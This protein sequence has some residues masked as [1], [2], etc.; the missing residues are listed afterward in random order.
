M[1]QLMP[2][3]MLL[4]L[5]AATALLLCPL[6][7]AAAAG[8]SPKHRV[9]L[10]VTFRA[11]CPACQWF[12]GD[13]LLELIRN[14]DFR[15]IVDLKLLPA[16]G[17]TE[18]NGA[19]DCEGGEEECDGHRWEACVIDKDRDD[20]VKYLGGIACIE[21][22]ESG[23][24]GEWTTK[25]DNCFTPE[26]RAVLKDCYEKKSMA[27][28]TNMI[29]NERVSEVGWMPYTVV[30]ERVLGS[31]SRG[32]GLDELQ[33]SV[34][35]EYKGPKSFYPEA[36]VKLHGEQQE[37]APE[38]ADADAAA[39]AAPTQVPAA[40]TPAA[41]PARDE[42]ANNEPAPA[43]PAP[44]A[45]VVDTRAKGDD[46]PANKVRVEVY[47]RAFCPGCMYFI[48]KPLLMLLRDEQFR[49]IVD[50]RP[51]P[52]AGTFLDAKGNFMCNKGMLECVGHKWLSCVI[53]QFPDLGEQ[54]EHL[55]CMEN[56]DNKGSSWDSI[57]AK[58]FKT[59]DTRRALKQCF[60]TRSSALLKRHIAQREKVDVHWM[61][62][63]LVNGAPVGDARHGIGFK[64][65]Q[66]EV[67]KAY[68]G[69]AEMRPVACLPKRLRNE[70][71]EEDEPPKQGDQAVRPCPQKKEGGGGAKY[72]DAPGAGLRRPRDAD[73][74]AAAAADARPARVFTEQDARAS[75]KTDG[76]F[77]VR[78]LLFP[79]ACFVIV[80]FVARQLSGDHKKNA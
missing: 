19:F 50:F 57:V 36:C 27:L 30:N 29:R 68:S 55:A 2:R 65:L 18:Q 20:V 4:L 71:G 59:E 76:G 74:D 45:D 64:Q 23:E 53:D 17:M 1:T 44:N 32:V 14:E 69:S 46:D 10:R 40:A 8:V 34:C 75:K 15:N 73:A 80:A 56:R 26:E 70:D 37:F 48:T 33:Q 22:D 6:Q 60:D 67:C 63:V 52:A 41:L 9:G 5:L 72:E 28:L 62:Y 58:C 39:P 11:F 49:D 42:A 25:I 79:L 43:Q 38:E 78:S 61:P 77:S 7:S 3:V 21:G 54:I 47:W 66:E 16:A 12:V 13:P 31:A 35:A 51:V 24:L